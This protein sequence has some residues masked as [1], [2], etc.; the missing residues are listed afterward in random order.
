MTTPTI[1]PTSSEPTNT[2]TKTPTIL[3]ARNPTKAPTKAPTRE[4]TEKPSTVLTQPPT[5]SPTVSGEQQLFAIVGGASC[6]ENLYYGPESISESGTDDGKYQYYLSTNTASKNIPHTNWL[7]IVTSDGTTELFRIYWSFTTPKTLAERFI[8][9]PSG[10]ENVYYRVEVADTKDIYYFNA[11]WRFSNSASMSAN[12]FNVA[13][14]TCCFSADDGAWG[15]GSTTVDANGSG[16][17]TAQFWGIGNWDASDTTCSQV[18]KNGLSYNLGA[19]TKTYMYYFAPVPPSAEPSAAPSFK[20]T[21][22]PTVRPSTLSPTLRPTSAPTFTPSKTPTREP[23]VKPTSA[24]TFAATVPQ[25]P[26]TYELFAVL[27]AQSCAEGLYYGPNEITTDGGVG[28][29]Y[30][31]FLST[32]TP[33]KDL[34]H[35]EWVQVVTTDGK[36]ELFRIYWSFETPRTLADHFI[37]AVA[38][39]EKVSY[40][41][42]RK[43]DGAEFTFNG[44]WW[45]SNGAGDLATKFATP[46][47]QYGFSLDDGVWGAGKD[48][49]NGNGALYAS[50]VFWGVGNWDSA[51][52]QNCYYIHTQGSRAS[53]PNTKTYM[54][55]ETIPKP[56]GAPTAV[57]SRPTLVP[58]EQP[59]RVP[60]K[61][62][63][64]GPTRAPTST[65]PTR[66]P[67]CAPSKTP[68]RE[69]TV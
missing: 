28:G 65:A 57:P 5:V 69:P 52:V 29:N 23:T 47:V 21:I 61:E 12:K 60:T 59:T 20:P 68:T 53:Y 4:P 8:G 13:K 10:S 62:P 31:A 17:Y 58:S 46:T 48:A 14:S 2:P 15:A 26:D 9:A 66:A 51:D 64:T 35:T 36:N 32:N 45:F 7:Q 40:R 41:V 18:Y 39:G 42:V 49:I 22:E 44:V 56:S 43:S 55:F 33:N 30:P 25:L 19:K 50:V 27:T 24:P 37:N 16:Q 6:A 67:S 3:P 34:L 54:Y 1:I 38:S 11:K 63:T